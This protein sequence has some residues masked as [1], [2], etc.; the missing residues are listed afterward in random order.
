[1]QHVEVTQ[2]IPAPLQAVWNRYNDHGSW[3]QWAG[4]GEATLARE[5]DPPPNG[6][7]CVRVFTNA[8]IVKVHEEVVAFEPPTR[9]AY[10]LVKG[11]PGL[12][13]HLGEAIFT[14]HDGGTLITWRCQF[15]S[16]IPGMG[17][18]LRW[19]ITRLFRNALAGL[20]RDMAR[21]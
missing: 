11:G 21:P 12:R 19:F 4:L 15:N 14:P 1:M 18:V 6:V 9:M 16:K 2:I 3:G 20:A 7:G 8:G 5:G 13:D 10:R 17:G